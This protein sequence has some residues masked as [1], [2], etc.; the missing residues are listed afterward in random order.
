MHIPHMACACPRQLRCKRHRTLH[1]GM[2]SMVG[3]MQNAHQAYQ[4]NPQP[5]GTREG[6]VD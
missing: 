1:D 4:T 5:T 6:G 3:A 2:H